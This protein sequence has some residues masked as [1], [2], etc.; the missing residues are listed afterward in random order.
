MQLF[1]GLG[2]MSSARAKSKS[3]DKSAAKTKKANAEVD[4]ISVHHGD[5]NG[6]LILVSKTGIT[7]K[8]RSHYWL[9]KR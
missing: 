7:F 4:K 5:P 8:V 9:S 3:K 2:R 1:Q 6:D